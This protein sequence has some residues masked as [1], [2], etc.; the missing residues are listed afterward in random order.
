MLRGPVPRDDR[1]AIYVAMR[2][3]I[4]GYLDDAVITAPH[5]IY[6]PQRTISGMLPSDVF[7]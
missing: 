7:A 2:P 6:A 5:V 3:E 4:F 1:V